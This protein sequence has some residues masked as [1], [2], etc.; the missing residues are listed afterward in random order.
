MHTAA[1]NSSKEASGFLTGFLFYSGQ[2][3]VN[4]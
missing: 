1:D 4:I 3:S 2:A